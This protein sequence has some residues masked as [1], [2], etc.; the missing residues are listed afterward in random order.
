MV[1]QQLL[2]Y[3]EDQAKRGSSK[4]SITTTLLSNDWVI[5]DIESAFSSLNLFTSGEFAPVDEQYNPNAG[6]QEN[7]FRS[8]QITMDKIIEKFIPIVGALFLI[9]GLGYLIYANAWVHLSME[10]RLAFGFF[11]SVVIIGGSFSLPE[12]MRYFTDLGIG[13]GVLML[14]GTLIYGSRA[15]EMSGAIIPEVATLITALLFTVSVAYFASRRNSKLI[16]ILGMIGAY[17]TPFVIGQ[18]NVWVDNISFNSYLFYFLA[19]SITVFLIGREI[20]VRDI[21]PLNIIGLFVGVSTLWGLASFSNISD[22]S[23]GNFFTSEIMT[24]VLFTSV[25]IFTIWSILVSSNKFNESDEGYLSLGYIAP[26]VWFIFNI[27]NLTSVPDV[28]I[29][30][31]YALIAASCFAG[32]HVLLNAQTRLQHSTLYAVG[33]FSTVIAFFTFFQELNVY[34][35][36]F[37]AYGSLV[38]AGLYLFGSEKT[39]RFT[40]YIILSVVGSSLALYQILETAVVY[41]S[42][43]VVVALA[44]AM[45]AYIIV[46][47][48]SRTE[49]LPFAKMYSFGS[50]VLAALFVLR[51]LVDYI[52]AEFVLFYVAPLAMLL[53]IAVQHKYTADG[54]VHKTKSTV[55]RVVL[56][57]FALG[58]FATFFYLI[59]SIYPAPADAFIF[60]STGMPLDWYL[61]K[62]VFA[63][64][65]LFVG[66]DISRT[67]QREEAIKRP[68][69]LLVIFGYSTLLL[70][71]NYIISALMNDMQISLSQGGPRA[72][73]TT[74]WWAMIAI[75]ML[76]IGI[77]YG[78]K[79]HSEKLLGL[80]LLALTVGKVVL[81]DIATMGMQNKIIVLMLVGG[82][83]LLFSYYIRSKDMLAQSPEDTDQI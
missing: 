10:I 60:S 74:I 13:S 58:F 16:L 5:E 35:G 69:F 57:W 53:Y 20:S 43:H 48:S 78:K 4:N 80:T 44:P 32:W 72:V 55:L 22:V 81:Y 24:A 34:T 19:I 76:I 67:L 17:I 26:V 68:S 47:N 41:E 71:G 70:T 73:V 33:L 23:A 46:K 15:T 62:G 30:L 45:A 59:A 7:A 21:I 54:M 39:E 3:V 29:G 63:T 52:D 40:T 25:V 6:Q 12:K 79:Y 56:A 14:Y 50:V 31:M 75:Y 38:F 28:F 66:L 61:I 83:M 9:V 82:G 36:M 77:K 1:N 42:L 18:N 2:D 27:V 11:A 51:D 65:I 49:F 8:E 37:I 64:I